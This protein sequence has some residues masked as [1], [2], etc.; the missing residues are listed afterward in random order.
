VLGLESFGIDTL[1]ALVEHGEGTQLLHLLFG[2]CPV[3][4][5]RVQPEPE[6][7][8]QA[9]LM[10]RMARGGGAAAGLAEIAHQ[11][12][13][14]LAVPDLRGQLLDE[15]AHLRLGEVAAAEFAHHLKGRSLI[16]Q[17]RFRPLHAAGAGDEIASKSTARSA[18]VQLTNVPV[19]IACPGAASG[20]GPVGRD[21]SRLC[22][23]NK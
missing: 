1:L 11:Q 19:M 23:E 16:G 10:A 15:T 2:Q 22:G 6:I 18:G 9:G 8:V 4:G 14:E 5:G 21:S 20:I 13:A 3:V 12:G 17:D 7:P